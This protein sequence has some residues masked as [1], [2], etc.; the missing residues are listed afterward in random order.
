MYEWQFTNTSFPIPIRNEIVVNVTPPSSKCTCLLIGLCFNRQI[1]SNLKSNE[2]NNIVYLA[3]SKGKMYNQ[4]VVRDTWRCQAIEHNYS[5]TKVVTC[6]ILADSHRHLEDETNMNCDCNSSRFVNNLR[7][8]LW[9]IN[10]IY[11]D[12]IRMQNGYLSSRFSIMFI[13][14]LVKIAKMKILCSQDG[15]QGRV[16][17]PFCPHFLSLVY[18]CSD[19]K[20]VF[21]INYLTHSELSKDNHKLSFVRT[22]LNGDQLHSI[23]GKP[24]KSEHEHNIYSKSEFLSLCPDHDVGVDKIKTV[25]NSFEN[26]KEIRYIV[27]TVIPISLPMI[28][29][30]TPVINIFLL[31][32]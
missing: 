4:S 7:S 28:N 13:K 11:I 24:A 29:K 9:E 26:V 31:Q 17:L 10:E 5:N 20:N 30:S 1:I 3:D 12:S 6:S 8:K 25:L 32:L 23:Y 19:I 2:L 14:N 27:L 15:K 16:Y 18:Q 21:D 22:T